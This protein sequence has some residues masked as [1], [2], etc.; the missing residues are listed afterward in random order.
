MDITF[1]LGGRL[2]RVRLTP[3]GGGFAA[4]VDGA[5]HRV[6]SLAAGP[7]ATAAGGATVEELALEVD[8]RP[9]RAIVARD[10]ERVLVA[11]RG[12]VFGFET[13]EELPG[14]RAATAGSGSVAAPMPGKVV[15]VLVGAGEAIV[16][17]QPLVVLEAMKMEST[18]ASEVAG[19][20]TAVR[21]VPG[22]LVAAG[23]LLVEITPAPDA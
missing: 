16:P 3:E 4:T 18:L 14:A 20:V 17:G 10:P 8:G 7:R 12:R 11:L 6:A 2:L 13:G 9:H 23:D 15:A 22:A 21:V 19:V 1:R 5:A